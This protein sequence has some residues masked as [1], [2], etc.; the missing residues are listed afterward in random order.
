MV[1]FNVGGC[2]S[3]VKDAEYQKYVQKALAAYD[4]LQDESGAG[5]DFLGWKTLPVDTPES[6]IADCEAIRDAWSA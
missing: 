2:N 6:M 3:F 5:N 1:K 4:V